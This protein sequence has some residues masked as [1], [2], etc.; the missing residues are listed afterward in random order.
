MS[1]VAAP[2]PHVVAIAVTNRLPVF[3]LAVP[4]EV[5]GVDRS[6]IVSPWYELWMCA[7]EPGA[8]HTTAGLGIDAKYGL[9]D[10]LEADTILVPR[11]A[12]HTP[13]AGGSPR[14]APARIF[15]PRS[16]C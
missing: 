8:L 7:A 1:P 4:C 5:F 12:R 6:D 10:L 3:E 14:S 13:A 11:C 15:W 2:R 9:E 16:A